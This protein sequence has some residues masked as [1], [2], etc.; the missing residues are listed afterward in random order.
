MPGLDAEV[1]GKLDMLRNGIVLPAPTADGAAVEL[2]EIATRLNSQYGKGKGTLNG[3]EISGSDIE[4]EMGNL[5]RTPEELAEMWASWHRNVGA[6]MK[7]DY[8]RMVAIAN[9]GAAE[10]G[11]SDV[12]AMW[13]SGYGTR[14]ARTGAAAFRRL[15]PPRVSF[16]CE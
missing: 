15:P 3:E 12:G 4:A 16:T 14:P 11:F 7:D 9:D 13:R 8:E 1:A 6:P 5:E 10:L 2:N